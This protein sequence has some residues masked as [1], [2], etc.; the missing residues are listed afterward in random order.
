MI[1]SNNKKIVGRG[2][3]SKIDFEPPIV[4]IVNT[5]GNGLTKDMSN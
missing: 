2:D 1:F 4:K 3:L 5:E